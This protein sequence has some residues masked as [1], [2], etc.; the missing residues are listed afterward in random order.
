MAAA[1]DAAPELPR[2]LL[3]AKELPLDWVERARWLRCQ[4]V[5]LNHAYTTPTIVEQAQAA[6][7]TVAVWTVNDLVRAR[8]LLSWGCNAVITDEIETIAPQYF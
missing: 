5:N 6:G 3:I 1:R 7:L 8:E 2:A 4:G